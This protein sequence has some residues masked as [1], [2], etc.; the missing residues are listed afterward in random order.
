MP[1]A[2]PCATPTT[3][4][5]S[6]EP[7]EPPSSDVVL[8]DCLLGTLAEVE[9]SHQDAATETDDWTVVDPRT[10]T[11]HAIENFDKDNLRPLDSSDSIEDTSDT[12]V[13][14]QQEFLN[15]VKNFNKTKLKPTHTKVVDRMELVKQRYRQKQVVSSIKRKQVLD[16]IKA[17]GK[18]VLPPVSTL[19][20]EICRGVALKKTTP[21]KRSVTFGQN[22]IRSA[23]LQDIKALRKSIKPNESGV[24]TPEPLS[25]ESVVTAEERKLLIRLRQMAAEAARRAVQAQTQATAAQR[26]AHVAAEQASL[27]AIQR[28]TLAEKCRAARTRSSSGNA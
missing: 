25:E 27:L 19:Q 11:M 22:L 14:P 23:V 12:F 5:A 3:E 6:S 7:S 20:E 9:N 16:S 21:P 28:D 17:M 2:T 1:D 18:K 26:D 4:E 8:V 24:S 10:Q 13:D 15:S